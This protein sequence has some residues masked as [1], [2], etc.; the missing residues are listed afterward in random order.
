MSIRPYCYQ[1]PHPAVTTDVVLF[2]LRRD[3]LAL[4]LIRRAHEPFAGH[5]AL[6]GGFLEIDEDLPQCAARELREETGVDGL[7]LRQVSAFGRPGR[8]PRERVISVVY[9]AL[10]A[11]DRLAPQAASDASE[12]DWFP[13]GALPPLAFDHEEVIRA[14]HQCLA[15]DMI[16]PALLAPLLPERFTLAELQAV[17]QVLLDAPMETSG[18]LAWALALTRVEETGEERPSVRGQPT[19]VYRLKGPSA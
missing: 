11:H 14:A 5:W 12:A 4:L 16:D 18:A 6:P 19:R 3:G 1:Y 13:L 15:R 2:T 7:T 9:Y 17:Y 10:A 8:D